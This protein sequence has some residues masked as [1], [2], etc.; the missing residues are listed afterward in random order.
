MDT[1]KFSTTE[2]GDSFEHKVFNLVKELIA[3]DDFFVPNK[4][5]KIFSKKKY[6]SSKRQGN[7]TVDIAIE[8]YM[9]DAPDYS[10]LVI[11]EC[12]DLGR[13]VS[14]DDIE[15]FD[16]KISGIGEHNTKGLF[17]STSYFT[18]EALKTAK[19]LKIG[20]VKINSDDKFEW[21][22]YR[23]RKTFESIDV[24]EI[25][26]EMTGDLPSQANFIS[27]YNSRRIENV[28]DL[29]L[30]YKII[31]YYKHLEKFIRV[32]YID[33]ATI[34]NIISKLS[35]YGIYTPKL[36]ISKLCALMEEKYS[37]KFELQIALS[38]SILGKIEF[39]PLS[40]SISKDLISDP[41]RQRFTISHEIGH[42]ILHSKILKDKID[43][44]IDDEHTLSLRENISS[45]ANSRLEWQANI[46]ASHLLLPKEP[47]LL[48]VA[49]IFVSENIRNNR[50]YLDSQPVNQQ[51][52]FSI[53]R[54]LGYQF[55]VS[56]EV[57]KL[58][59]IRLNLLVDAMDTSTRNIFKKWS[60]N[61]FHNENY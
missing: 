52:V 32:R 40:I 42:L 11:I 14:T 9:A 61:Q 38:K 56:M 4:R 24:G 19:F 17:I 57:V 48:E 31:D 58:R 28:A 51:L 20:L 45:I 29:L 21:I 53:L 7:I 34:D 36:D 2:K 13:K 10:Q 18:R 50:L 12:K 37:V 25:A 49:K 22:N 54:K 6:F 1:T 33:E 41:H 55:G 60:Q 59:L 30:E 46:F 47:F 26:N 23:K 3:N 27:Y 16:S 43:E 15:E 39:D 5:S 35:K 44:R 8:T